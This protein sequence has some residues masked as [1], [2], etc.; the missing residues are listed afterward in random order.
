[1][2]TATDHGK[3]RTAEERKSDA[4]KILASRAR[5]AP[6]DPNNP[7]VRELPKPLSP[8]ERQAARKEREEAAKPKLVAPK[9]DKKPATKD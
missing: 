2:T 3:P 5:R 6:A 9:A 1:M 8:A 4:K 7:K